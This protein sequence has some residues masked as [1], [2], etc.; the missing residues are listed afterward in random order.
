MSKLLEGRSALILGIANKW[1]LAYSIAEAFS[2][3]GAVLSLSYLDE[4]QKQSIEELSRDWNV[5]AI[6]PCDVTRE[7]QLAALTESLRAT[8]RPLHAVVHS[9]AFANR[10]DLGRP[11]VETGRQGFLL[12]QEVSAYSLVAVARATAPLMTE[13]GSLTTL[14]YIGSTRVVPNYNV[15][16]VAKASLEAA[17]RYLASDLGPQKIRVNAISAGPVKTASARAV[18]DFSSILEW[19]P[20]RA[21]LRHNTEP[22]EVADAAVF[23][24]SDLARGVTGNILFV[25]SGMQVMGL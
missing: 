21:P 15:M 12:A 4:R 22:A 18:K 6:L 1:S 9:L 3:H 13:G 10:E 14:T 2:R 7:E 17:T 19:G 11:F 25:D 8:G 5:A 23:L 20:K 16:G 24:A